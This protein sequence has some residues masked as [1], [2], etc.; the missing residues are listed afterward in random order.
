ME[1]EPPTCLRVEFD[2]AAAG[3]VDPEHELVLSLIDLVDMAT[4]EDLPF[5]GEDAETVRH[6]RGQPAQIHHFTCELDPTRLRPREGKPG[7]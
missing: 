6:T 4:E 5:L 7:C 2:F 3:D 1:A